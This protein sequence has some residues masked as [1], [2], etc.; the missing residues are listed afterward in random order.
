MPQTTLTHASPQM[1]GALAAI[2]EGKEWNQPLSF[3]AHDKWS[4]GC[5]LTTMIT[6]W[7]NPF[8]KPGAAFDGDDDEKMWETVEYAEERQDEWVSLLLLGGML[9]V[10]QPLVA[11]QT[12]QDCFVFGRLQNLPSLSCDCYGAVRYISCA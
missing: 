1:L 12:L 9:T 10:M 3:I 8:A 7:E 5:I 11:L 2:L 4:L 6:E